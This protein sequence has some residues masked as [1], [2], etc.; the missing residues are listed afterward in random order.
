M[1][2]GYTDLHWAAATCHIE[3]LHAALA[4]PGC[5]VNARTTRQG[6]TALHI[7]ARSG[8]LPV[9]GRQLASPRRRGGRPPR[10]EEAAGP[11]TRE[12][13]LPLAMAVP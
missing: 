12:L 2:D 1:T 3:K 9:T 6:W 7:A 5:D 11:T 13:A 8:F 4:S 10:R